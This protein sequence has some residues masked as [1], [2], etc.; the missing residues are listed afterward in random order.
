M[1]TIIT[2]KQITKATRTTKSSGFSPK[3]GFHMSIIGVSIN[4]AY[5]DTDMFITYFDKNDEFMT[6]RVEGIETKKI[7]IQECY[8]FL[9]D[10]YIELLSTR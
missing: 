9:N 3:Y 5:T 7:F 4:K 6:K 2:K 1:K 10:I 8:N